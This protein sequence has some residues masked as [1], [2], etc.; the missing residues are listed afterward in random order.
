MRISVSWLRDYVDIAGVDPVVLE[1]A[2]VRVGLEVE[3][4]ID[5]RER[6]TGP[7]EMQD[8]GFCAAGSW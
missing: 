6:V 7:L 3:H 2:L 5:L 1:K 4:M 8:T